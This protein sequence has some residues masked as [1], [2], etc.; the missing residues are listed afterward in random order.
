MENHAITHI[1]LD[2]AMI[3]DYNAGHEYFAT[4]IKG[5]CLNSDRSPMAIKDGD[6]LLCERI[7]R[8]EFI[9]N[10]RA[11]QNEIVLVVPYVPNSLNISHALVKQFV[12][13]EHGLF[14]VFRAYNP[15]MNI[16]IG[17]D[18]ISEISTVKSI[19]EP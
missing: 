10:W 5:D 12:G 14:A 8:R 9:R 17:L 16:S 15:P 19:I 3:A 13:V 18:E 4:A 2:T 6:M 1:T 11:Y 7:G